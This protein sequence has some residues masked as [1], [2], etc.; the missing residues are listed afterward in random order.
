MTDPSV[1]CKRGFELSER[2][3]E[4]G[5]GLLFTRSSQHQLCKLGGWGAI[6]LFFCRSVIRF[7]MNVLVVLSELVAREPRDGPAAD[8]F[9]I[10]PIV[11]PML[12]KRNGRG[13]AAGIPS[14]PEMRLE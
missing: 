7:R 1:S 8:A 6:F 13:A 10:P 11:T 3:D 2:Q 4:Q 14:R 5:E 12:S 9:P